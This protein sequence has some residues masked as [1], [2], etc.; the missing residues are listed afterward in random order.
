MPDKIIPE[1]PDARPEPLLGGRAVALV[2]VVGLALFG[3]SVPLVGWEQALG[4]LLAAFA[5]LLLAVALAEPLVHRLQGIIEARNLTARQRAVAVDVLRV[6]GSPVWSLA[7]VTIPN[8]DWDGR[9]PPDQVN[10]GTVLKILDEAEGRLRDAETRA[11]ARGGGWI[12]PDLSDEE[13]VE[14]GLPGAWHRWWCAD[15]IARSL[16]PVRY[17][18]SGRVHAVGVDEQIAQVVREI[19][20]SLQPTWQFQADKGPPPVSSDEPEPERAG[21]DEES[22]GPTPGAFLHAAADTFAFCR[23]ALERIEASTVLNVVVPLVRQR[24]AGDPYLTTWE[25]VRAE[26]DR[27]QGTYPDSSPR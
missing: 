25:A 27:A 3:A 5:G 23:V 15:A 17:E 18:V 22:A 6:V 21:P 1:P 16:E 11:L 9:K 13:A 8:W 4:S 19:C 7:E 20:F 2:V 14:V 10:A 26:V 24:Q 12:R